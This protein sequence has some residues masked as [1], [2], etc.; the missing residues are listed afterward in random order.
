M[1]F[2]DVVDRYNTNCLKFDFKKERNKPEDIFPMWVADMDFRC[3]PEVINDLKTRVEHGIFGYSD[4]DITYFRALYSWYSTHF[5]VK[6]QRDW[7][8][9]TPGVVFALATAVKVFTKENDYVLINNP[10]Y[11]PF[12]EVIE[13]NH[14]QILS[15]DLI[16][17]NGHYEIDFNDLEQK[18]KEYNIKL[19][20]LCSPHNPVGRVWSKEELD[21]IVE[22]CK[23]YN[24]FIVSDEIHSDFVYEGKHICML[25]YQDYLDNIIVCTSPSKTFN[26]AG[27]QTSNILIP[28]KEVKDK[29]MQ[30]VWATGY[31]NI[32]ALGL[33]ACKSAYEHG[34]KWL[35]ELLEYLKGN[36]KLVEEYMEQNLPNIK[37][38]HPEGTYLLWIDFSGTNL[39][40]DEIINKLTYEAKLWLNSGIKYGKSGKGFQRLNI[41]LPRSELQHALEKIKKVFG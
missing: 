35:K 39:S 7:L 8:F 27:L 22:I 6:L 38:T 19:Y 34:D 41:A 4:I 11:N 36:V 40:D 3:P 15:S 33:V 1:N 17:N 29:F 37:V 10:V 28:N 18:I 14:R 9:N 21:K 30:E 2:D 31:S 26:L 13:D 32:N 25:N 24:V 16:N 23:R 5:N 12:S 20:L